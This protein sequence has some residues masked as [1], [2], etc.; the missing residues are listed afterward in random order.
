MIRKV[1]FPLVLAGG[2]VG[3]FYG[4]CST[5]NAADA[6]DWFSQKLYWLIL[7]TGVSRINH[8][9]AAVLAIALCLSL[10]LFIFVLLWKKYFT[11]VIDIRITKK[12]DLQSWVFGLWSV[13]LISLSIVLFILFAARKIRVLPLVTSQAIILILLCLCLFLFSMRKNAQSR[14]VTQGTVPDLVMLRRTASAC[15]AFLVLANLVSWTHRQFFIP[16]TPNILIIVA[17]TLRAD[18][19]NCYGYSR[20]TSPNIDRFAQ[21]S[22]LFEKHMS[23]APWTKPSM[24][25]F[26]TSL[27]PHEHLAFSW[28]DNL[29]DSSVTLAEVFQNKNYATVAVQTNPCLSV[30]SNFAQGFHEYMERP[31]EKGEKVTDIFLSWIEKNKK[32]PFFAYLHYMDTH[33]PYNAPEEFRD[34]FHL[35]KTDPDGSLDLISLDIRVLTELGTSPEERQSVIDLYDLAVRQFDRSFEKILQNLK[36]L[37][38]L[39]NTIIILTSDHG[40]EFWEHGSFGH[41]HTQYNE[42]LHVPL[43]I[44]NAPRLRPRRITHYTQHL[45]VFPAVLSL[46]GIEQAPFQREEVKTPLLL[47]EEQDGNTLIFF[48]AMLSGK[49][50]RGLIRENW[51]LIENT[52]RQKEGTG[53]T[54]GDLEKFRAPQNAGLFELYDLTQDPFETTNLSSGFPDLSNDLK[55]LILR[56]FST[57]ARLT[58]YSKKDL[59]KKTEELK[60]LGYIK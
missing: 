50:K 10:V 37:D 26:F 31:L 21:E 35:D 55:A 57:E 2:V 59:E 51:K 32:K 9:T 13:S 5:F 1:F 36:S 25:T 19:L 18:H 46:S 47:H 44:G 58:Q 49:E 52:N 45:D 23:N 24:G 14:K 15:A 43:I 4:L 33:M 54:L 8:S 42:L 30:E 48:E 40:E 3:F 56:K 22:V 11:R 39:E 12:K 60:A 17:D 34:I 16:H 27:Y 6:Q 7:E 29:S 20:L 38:V 53:A 41:G 28:L